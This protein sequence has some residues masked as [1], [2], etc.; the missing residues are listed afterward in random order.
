MLLREPGCSRAFPY[1]PNVIHSLAL[2]FLP[3]SPRRQ[4]EL[5]QGGRIFPVLRTAKSVVRRIG[6]KRRHFGTRI[7]ET[8]YS[9]TLLYAVSE[10]SATKASRR[11]PTLRA[12]RFRSGGPQRIGFSALGILRTPCIASGAGRFAEA[13]RGESLIPELPTTA[14]VPHKPTLRTA[15]TCVANIGES[16]C[17]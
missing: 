15:H 10:V 2:M 1:S 4:D 16:S 13:A 17:R 14:M 6:N 12:D 9:R 7:S 3:P 5:G 11:Y 8:A